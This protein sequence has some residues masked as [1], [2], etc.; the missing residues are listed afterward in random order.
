MDKN[1]GTHGRI[2][3][4]A[5]R[6]KNGTF[7]YNRQTMSYT[8]LAHFP[9]SKDDLFAIF[10]DEMGGISVEYARVEDYAEVALKQMERA[11]SMHSRSTPLTR[12]D[13]LLYIGTIMVSRIQPLGFDNFVHLID[14]E[15]KQVFDMR[16]L[17]EWI[18]MN[19]SLFDSPAAQAVLQDAED[20]ASLQEELDKYTSNASAAA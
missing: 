3:E 14:H 19:Q 13:F 9:S 7:M 10:Q 12:D 5:R 20:Q 4:R 18:N 2:G 15:F 17:I 11:I 8:D 16:K 1:A 6:H